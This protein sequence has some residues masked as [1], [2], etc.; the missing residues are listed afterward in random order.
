V[1]LVAA[2]AL[3]SL[4][5]V[6]SNTWGWAD[7]RTFGAL[8]AGTVLLAAFVA[9]QRRTA[10][11]VLGLDLFAVANFRWANAAMG[12]FGTAFAAMFLASILFLTDVWGRSILRAGFAVSPGPLLVA[13]LAPQF[14]CLASRTGQRPLLVVGGLLFA[15][16]GGWRLAVLGAS[17]DYLTDYLPSML[18]TGCGVALCLPQLSSVVGQSV[19]ADRLGVGGAASQA[20]RQFGG[21][22]G[23]ALTI[24]AVGQ[25]ASVADALAGFDRVWW[26]IVAG[27]LAT[28]ALSTRLDTRPSPALLPAP[29]AASATEVVP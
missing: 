18:L 27:G 16:G 6:Q 20:V 19:A 1:V 11:P 5:V 4:G 23:V 13:A 26:L 24:G 15:A 29:P 25:A 3:V 12:T 2:A 21:T 9:H 10:A 8:G 7:G 17:P 22:L 28:A 14:G